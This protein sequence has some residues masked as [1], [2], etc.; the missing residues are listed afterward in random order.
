V[1]SHLLKLFMA[2]AIG[3]LLAGCASTTIPPVHSETERLALAQRMMDQ[4]RYP[5]AI[6]LLKSYVQN[7]GGSGNVDQ[8]H[9]LLGMSY[10]KNRDWALAATEFEQMIREYPESDSTASAS[11]RLGEALFAQ[12][13]D[14]DFDQDYTSRAIDQWHA[15]LEAYPNHWLNAEASRQMVIAR[16]RIATKLLATADLYRSLRLAGPARVYYEKVASDYNDTILLR[17]ALLG[18]ALCDVLDG[19]GP[20]ALAQLKDIES[21]YPGTDVAARAARERARIERKRGS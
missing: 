17:Q 5:S 13:R 4:K 9:Y 7:N 6:E 14:P 8:A 1:R 20:D 19:H 2:L 16:S 18:I 10:M 21:R 12:S 3:V 11:F 15:Y